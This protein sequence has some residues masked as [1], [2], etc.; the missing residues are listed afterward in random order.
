MQLRRPSPME[1]RRRLPM[2]VRRWTRLRQV[3][4]YSP[5]YKSYVDQLT[6]VRTKGTSS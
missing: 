2:E 4:C 3:D 5:W 6:Y 1:V